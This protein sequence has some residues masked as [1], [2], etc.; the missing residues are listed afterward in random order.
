M[1]LAPAWLSLLSAL[2]GGFV[3]ISV[4]KPLFGLRAIIF[5]FLIAPLYPV[6]QFEFVFYGFAF[7]SALILFGWLLGLWLGWKPFIFPSCT[8]PLALDLKIWLLLMIVGFPLSLAFNQG[9]IVDRVYFFAKGLL[10]FGYVSVFFVVRSL[11]FEPQDARRILH[12][13]VVIGFCFAILSY[14]IYYVA[15]GRVTWVYH[16]LAFPFVVLSASVSFTYL[17]RCRGWAE[18]LGRGLI[19]IFLL[20]AI[21][22]T[23]TKAQLIA[24]ILS[25]ALIALTMTKVYRS[26]SLRKAVY[27]AVL[28]LIVG[29]VVLFVLAPQT[30]ADF[31]DVL[32]ARLTDTGTRDTRLEES[33]DALVQFSQSP[34]IGK[35]VGYQLERTEF[36]ETITAGYVH[37]QVLYTAMTMGIAGLTIY[38]FIVTHWI[39]A[40]RRLK[41]A[42]PD[43]LPI[44]IACHACILSLFVFSLM[45]AAFRTIQHNYFLGLLLG[46][47]VV[48]TPGSRILGD[49]KKGMEI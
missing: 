18:N 32:S 6:E 22:L 49:I 40:M 20:V 9:T 26:D 43:T 4:R 12:A 41:Q 17:L 31:Y 27:F 10:P 47:I 42:N 11:R 15:G 35:G 14:V 45:F 33:Q 30:R 48:L 21:I 19:V 44:L 37:N 28:L 7:G 5:S 13:I 34:L 3:I 46:V 16:P 39:S 29:G 23:F 38:I 8:E 25:F 36:E 1:N 2:V 24:T